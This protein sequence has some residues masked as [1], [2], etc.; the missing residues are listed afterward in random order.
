M[1]QRL[2]DV[3]LRL[4][5]SQHPACAPLRLRLFR[6][7]LLTHPW[8]RGQGRGP[9]TGPGELLCRSGHVPRAI[10]AGHKC[11]LAVLCAPA[12]ACRAVSKCIELCMRLLSFSAWAA[13]AF[14]ARDCWRQAALLNGVL[15]GNLPPPRSLLRATKRTR[16]GRLS[17]CMN[18]RHTFPHGVCPA[19]LLPPVGVSA[20]HSQQTRILAPWLMW[21]GHLPGVVA[22]Q[23][24][25]C[26]LE[27]SRST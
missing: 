20:W 5:A 2:H 17:T 23:R 22:L 27:R 19:L 25:P 18:C 6:T 9:A 15:R 1:L 4:R 26:A 11:Q 21:L 14:C 12:P 10:A 8:Q 3:G 13:P 24:M 16:L 7:R